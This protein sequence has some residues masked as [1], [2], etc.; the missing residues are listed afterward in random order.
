MRQETVERPAP[1]RKKARPT[2]RVPRYSEAELLAMLG[3]DAGAEPDAGLGA[4]PWFQ[5]PTDDDWAA[6]WGDD[7]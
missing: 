5:A 6:V 2:V 1:E 7:A 4:M 3:I